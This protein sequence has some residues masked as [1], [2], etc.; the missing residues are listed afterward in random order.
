MLPYI[1]Y[2]WAVEVSILYSDWQQVSRVLIR[3]MS[4]QLLSK[5][6][7]DSWGLLHA[8][9]MP[10]PYPSITAPVMYMSH[11]PLCDP[12]S[13]QMSCQQDYYRFYKT[14]IILAT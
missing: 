14:G 13:K 6:T 9:Q 10:Q 3:G 5:L 2:H 12:Y 11:M 4:Y 7:R 1:R 8:T